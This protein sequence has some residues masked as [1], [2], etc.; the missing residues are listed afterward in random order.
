MRVPARA[1]A[2]GRKV[3]RP[4]HDFTPRL[5]PRTAPTNAQADESVLVPGGFE[6]SGPFG[7]PGGFN[8]PSTMPVRF[9]LVYASHLAL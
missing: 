5:N 7:L 3:H 9:R 2:R 8:L 1:L 6:P 4:R